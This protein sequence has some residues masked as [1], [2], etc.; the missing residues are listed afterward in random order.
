MKRILLAATTALAFAAAQ[1]A[2]AADAPVYKGPA[3]IAAATFN[4]SGF[5]VG[6]SGGWATSSRSVHDF[7]GGVTTSPALQGGLIG[8]TLGWN[9]QT[10][11]MVFGIEGD[12]SW[13]N[14]NGRTPSPGPGYTDGTVIN[15]LATLRGRLGVVS[16]NA[17]YF[18][19]AGGAW[20]AV[21]RNDTG[22]AA[23]TTL[24]QSF[25]LSGWTAGGGAE[26]ML[27]PNW[28]FKGEVLWVGL[29]T[30]GALPA[31]AGG[32]SVKTISADIW[33]LRAGA[34]FKF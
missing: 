17:L 28:T 26:F 31:S 15:S 21:D 13:A 32:Y 19:T 10:G 11:A 29:G 2:I 34:N 12:W 4:W 27:A 9:W 33:V 3:P 18:L 8:G 6:I 20:A 23:P 7:G 30:S 25:T 5:Y 14:I 1:P 16:G 22:P 24:V